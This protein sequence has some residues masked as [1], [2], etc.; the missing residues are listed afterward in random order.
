MPYLRQEL[1][2]FPFFVALICLPSRYFARQFDK[3]HFAKCADL[4]PFRTLHSI[5]WEGCTYQ[6]KIRTKCAYVNYKRQ[7]HV[8]YLIER[9]HVYEDCRPTAGVGYLLGRRQDWNMVSLFVIPSIN[10]ALNE[11][12]HKKTCLRGLRPGQ[13]QTGLLSNRSLEILDIASISIILSRQR[14][15]LALIRAARMRMLICAFVVRIAGYK[16]GFL[17]TRLNKLMLCIHEYIILC[18]CSFHLHMT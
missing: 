13:T 14:T 7:C 12:R 3:I 15:A 17:M 8:C 9:R 4:Q 2:L 16:A 10:R 1:A 5:S 6:C 18:C 11:P